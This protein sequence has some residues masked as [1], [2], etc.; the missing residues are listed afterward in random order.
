MGGRGTSWLCVSEEGEQQVM[1]GLWSLWEF[2][3]FNYFKKFQ[4]FTFR[5]F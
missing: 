1:C 4:V 5:I 2:Q 3:N